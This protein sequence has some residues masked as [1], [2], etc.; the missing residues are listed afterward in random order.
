[1]VDLT[2]D[3]LMSNPHKYGF[4]T[5]EEFSKNPDKW[6]QK[7]TE[8]LDA[9]DNSTQVFRQYVRK[10]IYEV[11]GYQTESVEELE[12]IALNEGIDP[13]DLVPM[14][15]LIPLIG[16][17]CDIL[18]KFERRQRNADENRSSLGD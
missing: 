16:G 11:C 1:M 5:L 4:C 14:P 18:I 10:Q 8:V 7:K 12:R 15:Q 2:M 17:Q 13:V 6:R 9:V 3:E